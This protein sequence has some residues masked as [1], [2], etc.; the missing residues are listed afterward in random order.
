MD[1]LT[2]SLHRFKETAASLGVVFPG[3]EYACP[4]WPWQDTLSDEDDFFDD[5]DSILIEYL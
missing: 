4:D 1:E 5:H 2:E 3:Y